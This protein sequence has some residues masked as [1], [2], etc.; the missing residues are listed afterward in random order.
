MLVAQ[1]FAQFRYHVIVLTNNECLGVGIFEGD[2]SFLPKP[3]KFPLQVAPAGS[4]EGDGYYGCLA[5]YVVQ[6]ALKVLWLL[7]Q[8]YSI[9]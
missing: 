5:R 8:V 7:N 3:S 9:D 4:P 6:A 2:Y 1:D